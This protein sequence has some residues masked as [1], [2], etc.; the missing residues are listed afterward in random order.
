MWV[1][2][3]RGSQEIEGQVEGQVKDKGKN[4]VSETKSESNSSCILNTDMV[5]SLVIRKNTRVVQYT[6]IKEDY[7]S[8]TVRLCIKVFRDPQLPVVM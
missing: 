2:R 4:A 8:V 5:L 6:I 7:F 1:C 3:V